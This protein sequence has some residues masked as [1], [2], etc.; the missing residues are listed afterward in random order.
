[1]HG[2]EQVLVAERFGEELHRPGLQGLHRHRDVA[3][4]RDEDNWQVELGGGQLALEVQAAQPGQTHV[5][6]QA[7][8]AIRAAVVQKLV[9][10]RAGRDLQPHRPQEPL[11][12][13][14]Q[15]IIPRFA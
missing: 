10:R 13:F 5:E 15:E 2:V 12:R 7:A 6:H 4:A 3:I 11:Q 9:R 8:G 14:A 1:M